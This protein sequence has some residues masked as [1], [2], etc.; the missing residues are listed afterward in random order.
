MSTT[1]KE[2]KKEEKKDV[3]CESYSKL[4][5]PNNSTLVDFMTH[6]T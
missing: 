6:V 1:K 4:N 5:L 2:E 3:Y